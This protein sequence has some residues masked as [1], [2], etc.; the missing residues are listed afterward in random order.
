MFN[1]RNL[2]TLHC[3]RSS[4]DQTQQDDLWSGMK[5]KILYCP[6]ENSRFVLSSTVT[7]VNVM[8]SQYKETVI[9]VQIALTVVTG[10][11]CCGKKLFL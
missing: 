9:S 6:L 11:F 2:R 7:Y 5:V 1:A 4:E 3:L 10:Y 8:L